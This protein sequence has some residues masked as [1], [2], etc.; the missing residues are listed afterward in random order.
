MLIIFVRNREEE[1]KEIKPWQRHLP[2]KAKMTVNNDAAGNRTD[3]LNSSICSKSTVGGRTKKKIFF[4]WE[5]DDEMR[6]YG[7]RIENKRISESI[8]I[9]NYK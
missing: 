9:H 6:I 8:F 1:K 4:S 2:H 5:K 7:K 3:T